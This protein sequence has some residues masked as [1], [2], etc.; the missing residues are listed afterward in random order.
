VTNFLIVFLFVL[1][2]LTCRFLTFCS[3][4]NLYP[5]YMDELPRDMSQLPVGLRGRPVHS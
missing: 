3:L 4:T 2:A 1:A 5:S